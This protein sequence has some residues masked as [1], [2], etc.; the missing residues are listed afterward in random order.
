MEAGKL[1]DAE[2]LLSGLRRQISGKHFCRPPAGDDCQSL[3]AA[4]RSAD[5][6]QVLHEH[7]ADAIATHADFQLALARANQMTGSVEEAARLYR[8]I[9]LSF[10]LS[11]EGQQAKA[12]LAVVGAAAPLTMGERRAHADALYA[13]GR[14]SEA[15]EEYRALANDSA[16]ADPQAKER[17][18]GSRRGLRPEDQAPEQRRSGCAAGYSGRERRAAHVSGRGTGAQQGRWRCAASSGYADGTTIS[19]TA[20]GWP[21]RSTLRETCI[22]CAKTIPRPSRTTVTWPPVFPSTVMRPAATGRRRG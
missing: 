11:N 21:K 2:T 10:P 14:Y 5:G 8:H 13:G 19:R 20:R 9:F 1:S 6:A 7:A 18:S 17:A 3:A 16:Q 22:C 4:K 12:Q 15:G